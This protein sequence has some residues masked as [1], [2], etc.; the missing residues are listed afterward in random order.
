MRR[1]KK[2]ISAAAV[3]RLN[4][5]RRCEKWTGDVRRAAPCSEVHPLDG[6]RLVGCTARRQLTGLSI[7]AGRA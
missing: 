3:Y 2:L 7:F 1:D 4:A 6:V 5:R